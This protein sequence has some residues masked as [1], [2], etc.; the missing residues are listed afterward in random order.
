MQRM[1]IEEQA[2][3]EGMDYWQIWVDHGVQMFQAWEGISEQEAW[4][5]FNIWKH[6]ATVRC[7]KM[8]VNGNVAETYQRE[9]H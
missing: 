2:Q 1:S 4:E 5:Q 7:V 9:E 8:F 3:R 6:A